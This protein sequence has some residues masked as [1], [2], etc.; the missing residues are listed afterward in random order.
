[1]VTWYKDHWNIM[2]PHSGMSWGITV[3]SVGSMYTQ[4]VLNMPRGDKNLVYDV[5]GHSFTAL[6]YC[7]NIR[8]EK[9][10]NHHL[11]NWTSF[12]DEILKSCL[13]K[14]EIVFNWKCSRLFLFKKWSQRKSDLAQRL[15]V[16]TVEPQR[17]EMSQGF[18]LALVER[19]WH[20]LR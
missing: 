11:K 19:Y 10:N 2:I 20:W 4:E 9:K 3:D 5:A 17:F 16:P 18:E 12:N 6:I 8:E 14:K 7:S 13:T 1:M 15:F